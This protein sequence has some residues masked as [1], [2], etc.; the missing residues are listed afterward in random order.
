M[1]GPWQILLIIIFLVL[2]PLLL[3]FLGYHFGKRKG[4]KE[5]NNHKIDEIGS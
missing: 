1:I 3:F 5:T 2:W 4:R